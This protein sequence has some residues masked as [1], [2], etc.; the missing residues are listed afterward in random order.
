[1][2]EAV[3]V[4]EGGRAKFM[5]KVSGYPRPRITWWVNGSIVVAGHRFRL[6]YDGMIHT[7]DI[8]KARDYDAG[9]VRVVAK[10]PLG[11]AECSTLLT[12]REK[13]DWRSLLKQAPRCK[14]TF[15]LFFFFGRKKK[16]L[17]TEK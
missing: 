16:L 7:L 11:E 10:N 6:R 17:T 8:P 14:Y 12:V 15:L 4:E 2:P 13:A 5:C 3:V 9:T 1:M